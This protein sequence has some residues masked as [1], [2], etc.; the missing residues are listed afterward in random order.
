LLNVFNFFEL[1]ETRKKDS[2]QIIRFIPEEKI[3]E[4]GD[5]V[6]YR[7]ESEIGFDYLAVP[8]YSEGDVDFF[9]S[10]T[11]G[12]I[13]RIAAFK[14]AANFG[15]ANFGTGTN[16]LLVV[17]ACVGVVFEEVKDDGSEI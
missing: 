2:I 5:L 13:I 10:N 7:G 9:M 11:P 8:K 12:A 3:R 15:I 6:I 4:F 16:N 17:P 1:K 14:E